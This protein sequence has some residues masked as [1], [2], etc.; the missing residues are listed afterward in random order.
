MVM[1]TVIDVKYLIL[2]SNRHAIL[3]GANIVH[4]GTQEKITGGYKFKV[5]YYKPIVQNV[6]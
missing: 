1:D 4:K 6:V 3:T 2:L 5:G